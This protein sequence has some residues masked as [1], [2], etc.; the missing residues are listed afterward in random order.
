MV[1]FKKYILTNGLRLIIHEDKSTPMAAVNLLYNVGSR[2]ESPEKTGFA[3]LFEHLMFGGSK[4]APNFDDHIQNAGGDC[5]AFTNNDLTNFYN[6]LPAQNLETALWLEADRMAQLNISQKALSIQRKVVVEEF[7]ETCLNEPYGDVWHHLSDLAYKVHPYRWPTIGKVPKHVED[8]SLEDVKSFYERFYRPN[9]AILVVAGNVESD[10]VVQLVEKWFGNIPAGPMFKRRLPKEPP[11]RKLAQKIQRAKVPLD[12]L[13]IAFHSPA[14]YEDDYYAVDLLSDVLS[15]GQSS[16]LYRKLLKEQELVS[17]VDCYITGS[18][19]PGLLIIEAKPADGV[20]LET[21]EKAIWEEIN[22]LKKI[23]IDEWE[24]QKLKNKVESNL[25]FSE[26]NVLNKAINLA[27]FELIEDIDL[28]NTEG[29][30]YQEL[31][32][33]DILVAAQKI[34]TED[35]CSTLY[36]QNEK[37]VIQ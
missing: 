29:E 34:L 22:L 7:K 8:A 17:S 28:I 23:S 31:M 9:N 36:Y 26:M 33:N 11:Q 32:P 25:V 6:I 37:A 1:Q 12:A 3:H 24:L 13:Y 14:R 20:S 5:N 2:D 27:F 30:K 4:N 15:N 18:I 10:N 21:V 16:R 19:D 35:N